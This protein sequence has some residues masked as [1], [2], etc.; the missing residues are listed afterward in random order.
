MFVPLVN[1][2]RSARAIVPDLFY[3]QWLS[4]FSKTLS[5]IVNLEYNF[6]TTV[7]SW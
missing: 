1:V 4:R 6:S 3:W 5:D 7:S 2:S